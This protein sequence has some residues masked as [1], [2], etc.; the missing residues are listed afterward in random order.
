MGDDQGPDDHEGAEA[1]QQYQEAGRVLLEAAVATERMVVMIMPMTKNASRDKATQVERLSTV[2]PRLL[3]VG[4]ALREMDT[5][6]RWTV[7]R[8]LRTT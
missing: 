8:S 6:Y 4:T 7:L 3:R 2:P 1:H 5:F